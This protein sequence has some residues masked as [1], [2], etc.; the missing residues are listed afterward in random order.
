MNA[1]EWAV[2]VGGIAAVAW[3]NWYFFRAPRAA[4]GAVRTATGVQEV[5]VVV[6]GGYEPAEVRVTRGT[7]VRITF[8]RREESGCSEEVVLP[9][10]GLRRFLPAFERT[11]IEFT[12]SRA[13]AFEFTCGM[14]M[15]RGRILV[16]EPPAESAG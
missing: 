7:P 9:D 13:G 5:D 15:L 8:D 4:S 2:L 12:P 11:T 1:S 10:F 14:G 16:E 6:S 3:V